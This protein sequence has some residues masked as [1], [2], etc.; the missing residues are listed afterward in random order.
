MNASSFLFADAFG[1]GRRFDVLAVLGGGAAAGV[2]ADLGAPQPPDGSSVPPS[3]QTL[4]SCSCSSPWPRPRFS[5]P[6]R[7]GRAGALMS[8]WSSGAA[9]P[10][11]LRRTW[12]RHGRLMGRRCCPPGGSSSLAPAAAGTSTTPGGG[13]GAGPTW[14]AERPTPVVSAAVAPRGRGRHA[15]ASPPIS[16]A[17]GRTCAATKRLERGFF[18]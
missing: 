7:L 8:S 16:L 5:W 17:S 1:E 4:E 18:F 12:A 6:T 13:A 15:T 14:T 11:V 10:R 3:R 9:R 2:A